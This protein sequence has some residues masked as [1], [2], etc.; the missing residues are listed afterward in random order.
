MPRKDDD[1]VMQW[2]RIDREFQFTVGDLRAIRA[3]LA[4][5]APS[6]EPQG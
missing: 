2:P 1:P 6:Q 3:A 5:L 4:L